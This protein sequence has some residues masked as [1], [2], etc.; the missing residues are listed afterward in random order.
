MDACNNQTN[1]KISDFFSSLCQ[2][3]VQKEYDT[4]L[5]LYEGEDD[6]A[7]LC[8]HHAKGRARLPLWK[9]LAVIGACTVFFA[10]LRGITSLFSL[11][12]D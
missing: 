11:F 10:I 7:P 6:R 2:Y 5:S 12:S 4:T 8:S 9:I 3:Q 1:R